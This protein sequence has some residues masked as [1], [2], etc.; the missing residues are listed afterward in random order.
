M[1]AEVKLATYSLDWV[2]TYEDALTAFETR[3]HDVYLVD[4]R[5]GERD[6]L[7]LLNEAVDRG[8][9]APLIMLTGLSD[10]DVDVKAMKAGA[11]DYLV[12]GEIS[13]RML[14]RSIRYAI[15]RKRG[16]AA[17]L[18]NEEVLR[19]TIESTA[20]GILVV[21]EE[22]RVAYANARFGEMWR[23]PKDLLAKGDDD[24]LLSYVLSQLDSPEAF[25]HKV[26]EL[27]GTANEDLDVL[28]F[29][30]GRVFERYSLPLMTDRAIGGRVWSFRDITERRELEEQLK[31]QAFH[32]SLTGL[33]NRARFADR[34]EVALLRSARQTKPVTV[35]FMDLDNFKS[36]NDSLG[37]GMG[38]RLLIEVAGR[39]SECLRPGDTVARFGGDEFTFLLEDA[40]VD[41]AVPIAKRTLSELRAPFLIDNREFFVRASIGIAVSGENRRDAEELLRAADVAMY[42]AKARGR[43]RYEVYEQTMHTATVERLELLR[44]LEQALDRKEFV[45]HYQPI[46]SVSTQSVVGFEALVRWQHPRRSIIL[47]TRFISLA[48]ECGVIAPLGRWVLLEACRRASE[49][50]SSG[51]VG[52]GSIISVNVSGMQL[53]QASFVAEVAA[54]LDET[55]L[56]PNRLVLEITE[57]TMMHDPAWTTNALAE[58][59]KLGVRIAIDDFGTGYSSL[60]SLRQFPFDILKIDKSFV[61]SVAEATPEQKLTRTIIDLGK[62]LNVQIVAEG[63]ERPEQLRSLQSLGCDLGQGFFF[64]KAMSPDDIPEFLKAAAAQQLSDAA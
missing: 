17:I 34:L 18:K 63:I 49:W 8:C 27:Y 29:K 40:D 31:H 38:D 7:G 16:E 64:A 5:L 48:E 33:A 61:D 54:I 57:T 3:E 47:P 41:D 42:A 32:D 13:P 43:N 15:E 51:S 10:E 25:L 9:Q 21:D 55:G 22:G 4:Y 62:T 37:H 1:L 44:D 20:D 45:V 6:G 58:L 60:S 36:V 52:A 2:S 28:S 24:Q 50:F 30:D 23:I 14:E 35:L 56:D 11:S 12:K 53:Q 59:K 26:K 39:L 19:A 46:V